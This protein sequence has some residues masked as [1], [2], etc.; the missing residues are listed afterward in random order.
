M[1][2]TTR[3]DIGW[4]PYSKLSPLLAGFFPLR[5]RLWNLAITSSVHACSSKLSTPASVAWP[6]NKHRAILF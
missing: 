2:T 6:V 1:L 4:K 5:M 3:G